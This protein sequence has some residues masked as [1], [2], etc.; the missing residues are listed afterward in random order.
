[1]EQ[2]NQAAFDLALQTAK[3]RP[4][5][6]LKAANIKRLLK[7]LGKRPSEDGVRRI[8]EL[9]AADPNH[10][11]VV[12]DLLCEVELARSPATVALLKPGL[13]EIA[14]TWLGNHAPDGRQLSDVL[15]WLRTEA[16]AILASSPPNLNRFRGLLIWLI[17]QYRS[18]DLF[19]T[20]LTE[21]AQSLRKSKARLVMGKPR[22]VEGAASGF[23]MVRVARALAAL[24]RGK[25]P[26][27]AKLPDMS[28]AVESVLS[29]LREKMVE[30]DAAIRNF[31]ETEQA[32]TA[33]QVLNTQ[34]AETIQTLESAKRGLEKQ[35]ASLAAEVGR[36]KDLHQQALDHA[37]SQ[38]DEARRAALTSLKSKIQPKVRDAHLYANRPSPAVD[39]VL[40]L[41]AEIDQVFTAQEGSR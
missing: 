27:L 35:T 7:L 14:M 22:S 6:L 38:V 40:R 8:N 24:G 26:K 21:L 4:A 34:Q 11:A 31:K 1:M 30:A 18:P 17:G 41:L 16:A 10:D 28:V 37:Q 12:Y 5:G 9:I 23:V 13:T 20:C 25:R 19:L 36:L 15:E 39:Q 32:L 3:S 2:H 29:H 33:Q